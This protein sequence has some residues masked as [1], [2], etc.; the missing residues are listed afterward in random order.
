MA[1]KMI[2]PLVFGIAGA[3][4]LVSLGLWQAQ[5]L[6]WK[7]EMLG[8]IEAQIA[9]P[10]TPLDE[11]LAR[12]PVEFEPISA[13]GRIT[14]EEIHVLSSI[15]RV[16]AIYRVVAAFET[17]GGRRILLDRGFIPV[18]AKADPRPGGPAA[19]IGNFRTVDEA[20]SYTPKPD[21]TA[22]IWFA[23]DVPAM[24]EALGTEPYLLILRETS[25]SDPS[26]TPFPVDTAGIP[27]DHLNY[28]ITW[29]SLAAIWLGMTGYFLWRLRAQE[30]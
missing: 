11:A 16:G 18:T 12:G 15:K 29:F 19:I 1:R 14:G 5:R 10:A 7:N 25:E 24:A 2:L 21:R 20:D 27:N 6:A 22:N 8:Q 4:V 26:V 28:A 13:E 23:R 3:V 17:K 9:G 30:A